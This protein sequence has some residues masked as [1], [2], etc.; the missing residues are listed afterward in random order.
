MRSASIRV[1][2]GSAESADPSRA[3]GAGRIAPT[4]FACDHRGV[5]QLA[6][7]PAKS[8]ALG[9]GTTFI[10]FS[11]AFVVIFVALVLIGEARNKNKAPQ[12]PIRVPVLRA[13]DAERERRARE[14]GIFREE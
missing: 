3:D 5:N 14:K 11:M 6:A 12:E 9:M 13:K 7:L 1:A 2:L 10:L 8:S 4:R